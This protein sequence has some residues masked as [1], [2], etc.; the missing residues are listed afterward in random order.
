MTKRERAKERFK[1][2]GAM[3]AGAAVGGG[4]GYLAQ[5]S[6]YKNHG[7]T[8][9]RVPPD[10]RLKYLVPTSTALVGGLAISKLLRDKAKESRDRL[11]REAG[12]P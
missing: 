7:E 10:V 3:A 2:I 4:L 5:R 11:K 12:K 6:L 9:R 1:D 8:L